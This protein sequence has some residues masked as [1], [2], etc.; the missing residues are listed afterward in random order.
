MNSIA[1][2]F[3]SFF[4]LFRVNYSEDKALDAIVRHKGK[5]TVYEKYLKYDTVKAKKYL[6]YI[7]KHSD[8]TYI[9]WD[10]NKDKFTIHSNPAYL[11]R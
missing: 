5:K 7:S 11:D 6:Q 2:N 9:M 8:A 1:I 3:N 4:N 10:E